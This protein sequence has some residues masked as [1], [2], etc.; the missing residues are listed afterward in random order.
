MIGDPKRLL[1]SSRAGGLERALLESGGRPGPTEE[2]R[3]AVWASMAPR[4]SPLMPAGGSQTAA[5]PR[6][7][8]ASTALVKGV[9]ILVLAGV[10][11]A[12]A[13]HGRGPSEH[14]APLALSPQP[15]VVAAETAQ[16]VVA[17]TPAPVDVGSLPTVQPAATI[18][19]PSPV[20]SKPSARE[21][22][23]VPDTLRLETAVVLRA[24]DALRRGDCAGA[25]AELDEARTHI[26]E[27]ALYQEREVLA[28]E[29]L[30]CARRTDQARER[31][32][33]FLRAYPG[34]PHA[35]AVQ[36]FSP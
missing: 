17:T 11:T 14:D 31:A 3:N 5:G 8:T 28:I 21:S 19:T 7:L 26:Q 2:Q 1:D 20:H 16:W 4:L 13:L 25:L 36:R 10:A 35:A 6:R 27:G 23:I 22:V 24:R 33:A 29:A 34:S 18:A 15:T 30:D 12:V 32:A 9:G